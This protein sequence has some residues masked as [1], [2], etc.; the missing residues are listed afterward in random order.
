MNLDFNGLPIESTQ[1]NLSKL[2]TE[3]LK[4]KE[5]PKVS[6]NRVYMVRVF[7]GK[8]F[9]RNED[10][11]KLVPQFLQ[12][13]FDAKIEDDSENSKNSESFEQWRDRQALRQVQNTLR[14]W[15]CSEYMVGQKLSTDAMLNNLDSMAKAGNVTTDAI[16]AM[17]KKIAEL[18][19]ALKTA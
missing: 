12:N 10:F 2:D 18:E 14:I 19:A 16:E 8:E 6:Y 3:K 17:K 11:V 7:G 4:L 9:E 15:A 5:C 1:C 13:V